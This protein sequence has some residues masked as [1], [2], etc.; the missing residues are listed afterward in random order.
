MC[1]IN[2]KLK[3]NKAYE[4]GHVNMSNYHKIGALFLLDMFDFHGGVYWFN[5]TK[6]SHSAPMLKTFLCNDCILG[7]MNILSLV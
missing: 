2:F 5:S 7:N 3:W 6:P 1:E 4:S